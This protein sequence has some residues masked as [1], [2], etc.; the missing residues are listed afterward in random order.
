MENQSRDYHFSEKLINP[1]I[2]GT[3]PIYYGMP[4]IG[5]YFDTRGMIIFNDVEEIG[6][7]LSSLNEE[8]YDSMLPYARENF[9]IAQDYIL[10]EDWMYEN[11]FKQMSI[12]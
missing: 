5:D 1:I 2:V 8:L 4:S 7:I 10:S 11:I 9:K 12:I 3:I 6:D